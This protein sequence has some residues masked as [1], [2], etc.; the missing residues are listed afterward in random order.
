[1]WKWLLITHC[2][3]S[4][5][6]ARL[7]C[8]HARWWLKILSSGAGHVSIM[9]RPGCEKV[10]TDTLS[11]RPLTTETTE[12]TDLDEFVL[13]VSSQGSSI[14]DLLDGPGAHELPKA[15]KEHETDDTN[16]IIWLISEMLQPHKVETSLPP[17]KK[18]KI[19]NFTTTMTWQLISSCLCQPM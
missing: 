1:M 13:W 18:R 8:K 19:K 4:G 11:H 3:G 17:L 2:Q 14:S 9:H 15:V 6:Q 10:G 12:A 5:G 16:Y 7:K